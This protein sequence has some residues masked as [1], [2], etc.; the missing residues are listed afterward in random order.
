MEKKKKK[1]RS[2]ESPSAARRGGATSTEA[3][4]FRSLVALGL[5]HESRTN[6]GHVQ[7]KRQRTGVLP[8]RGLDQ[9]RPRRWAVI[10]APFSQ[11]GGLPLS[12]GGINFTESREGTPPGTERNGREG[13]GRE[14]NG[15]ERK[16]REGNG[17]G[18][19]GKGGE[20][21]ERKGKGRERKGTEGNGRERNGRERKGTERSR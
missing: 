10:S 19:K 11:G 14:G 9:T 5:G 12:L 2:G 3:S 21:R 6:N 16:G 1:V 8:G 18:G 15:T 17:R 4:V 7:V 13:N 20:G